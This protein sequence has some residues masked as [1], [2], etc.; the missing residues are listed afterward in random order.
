MSAISFAKQLS[1]EENLAKFNGKSSGS[2]D[3]IIKMVDSSNEQVGSFDA[4]T[5]L[6]ITSIDIEHAG[7][8]S[9]GSASSGVYVYAIIIDY[10]A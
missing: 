4:K 1:P 2:S 3:R 8:Y 7:T 6:S 5:A 10:Y 9:V